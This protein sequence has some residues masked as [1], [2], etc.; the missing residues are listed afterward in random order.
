MEVDYSINYDESSFW[1]KIKNFGKKAG[2]EVVEKALILF[3]VLQD[4]ATPA[5]ART[6]IIGALGYFIFPVD[7]IADIIPVAGYTDDLGVLLGAIATVAA[8]I[9]KEHKSKAQ[10]KLSEWFD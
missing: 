7:L 10:H 6:V 4:S 8:C 3:F 2:R 1:E 9:S 5:W